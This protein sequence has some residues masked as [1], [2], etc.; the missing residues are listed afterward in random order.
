V[1]ILLLLILFKKKL[2]KGVFLSIMQDSFQLV[3]A[4]RHNGILVPIIVH[5]MS[6]NDLKL[7]HY[8]QRGFKFVH[9]LS[10]EGLHPEGKS[11][12]SL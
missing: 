6:E 1:T 12:K 9:P 10:P 5:H 2:G 3:F 7:A 11:S 8:T 4:N